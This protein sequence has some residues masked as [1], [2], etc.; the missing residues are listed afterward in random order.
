[1]TKFLISLGI[2]L[3]AASVDVLLTYKY[4]NNKYT[5]AAIAFHWLVVGTLMPYIDLGTAVWVKGLL[6]GLFLAVP[7]MIM[8]IPKDPKAL[9]PMIPFSCIMGV[10]MAVLCDKL[11]P[12]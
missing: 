3:G 2:G 9:I 7:F 10:I 5:F 6:V 11:V 8:E 1:M 4:E 12:R